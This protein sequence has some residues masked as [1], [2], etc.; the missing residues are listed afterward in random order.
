MDIIGIICIIYVV[1]Q[2]IKESITPKLPSDY[3]ANDDL[4]LKDR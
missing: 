3:W 2:L 1:F 4:I